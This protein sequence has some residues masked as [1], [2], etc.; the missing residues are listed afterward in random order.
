MA[1]L[2][3][4]SDLTYFTPT[5]HT[6]RRER[7]PTQAPLKIRVQVTK[8]TVQGSEIDS[9]L[10]NQVQHRL[11]RDDGNIGLVMT[12]RQGAGMGP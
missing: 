10:L 1:N 9:G 6:L 11:I 2:E 4:C 7:R 8:F 12:A 3:K 5:L